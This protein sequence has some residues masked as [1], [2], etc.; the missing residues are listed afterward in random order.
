MVLK[1]RAARQS[2][3]RV[4]L[5]I[6]VIKA[7]ST[8][9]KYNILPE[10]SVVRSKKLLN[11]L[12]QLLKTGSRGDKEFAA[13]ALGALEQPESLEP[14]YQ[15]LMDG[16]NHRG[17][18]TQSL[19][20]AI[21][22]AIGEIGDDAAVPYLRRA[23]AFTFKGDTFFKERQRLILSAAGCIA[24]Q[25]GR[26]ALE[27]LKQHLFSG[28]HEMRAHCLNELSVAYWHRPNEIPDD[29]I[30]ALLQCT[31]DLDDDVRLA[32]IA[33]VANLAELGCTRARR[34]LQNAGQG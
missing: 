33:S 10:I 13:L 8:E 3:D 9:E 20:T 14:L 6:Q 18:G 22:V 29:I 26:Q 24:Q 19:Q 1:S 4:G 32:A 15:A 25:G 21:V 12:L 7:G 28:E 31:G 34:H 5:C 2:E 17:T 16:E 23:L 27:L 30:E 11:P